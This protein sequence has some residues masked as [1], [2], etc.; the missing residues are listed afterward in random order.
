[1][2]FLEF[3]ISQVFRHNG[4]KSLEFITVGRHAGELNRYTGI[5]VVV[6]IYGITWICLGRFVGIATHYSGEF[7]G[8]LRQITLRI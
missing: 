2:I 1:M 6:N 4:W 3:P 8:S 7:I 5:L